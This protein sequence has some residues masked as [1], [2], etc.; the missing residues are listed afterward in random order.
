MK[1]VT[2]DCGR[3]GG[4]REERV[5]TAKPAA[6]RCAAAAKSPRR[7]GHGKNSDIATADL[8]QLCQASKHVLV[9]YIVTE[10]QVCSGLRARDKRRA[11]TSTMT[12]TAAATCRGVVE[13]C[14]L[15]GPKSYRQHNEKT[16]DDEEK[17]P[18]PDHR[19]DGAAIRNK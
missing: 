18:T 19:R 11:V 7:D 5:R 3:G 15:K 8:L 14:I 2:C 9:E 12:A 13:R 4:V 6:A 1:S 16:D 17:P 10:G